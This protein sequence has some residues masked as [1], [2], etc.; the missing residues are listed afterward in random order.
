MHEVMM[1]C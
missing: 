1:H